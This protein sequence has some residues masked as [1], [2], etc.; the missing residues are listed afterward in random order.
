MK[1]FVVETPNGMRQIDAV[2]WELRNS[3]DLVFTNPMCSGTEQVAAFSLGNWLA[4]DTVPEQNE[5]P[6]L[7]TEG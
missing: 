2:T 6:Q 5:G 7:L 1:K 3:G 4:V